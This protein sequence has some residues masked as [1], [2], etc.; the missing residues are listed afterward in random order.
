MS[1]NLH[2]IVVGSS[3]HL[4]GSSS[5]HK[6]LEMVGVNVTS[7][8]A[9]SVERECRSLLSNSQ[10]E[11]VLMV[12]QYATVTAAFTK[13]ALPYVVSRMST[14]H[15]A[16]YIGYDIPLN[17]WSTF[18]MSGVDNRCGLKLTTSC[19]PCVC[20]PSGI[21]LSRAALESALAAF[22]TNNTPPTCIWQQFVYAFK[23]QR[24][25]TA[26]VSPM[27]IRYSSAAML[28]CVSDPDS[29][30]YASMRFAS[31]VL[32]KVSINYVVSW[33]HAH[34]TA[35]MCVWAVSAVCFVGMLVYAINSFALQ[36][37]AACRQCGCR[38]LLLRLLRF[39][40]SMLS[41]K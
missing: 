7:C 25:A 32:D 6:H 40:V 28:E 11:Y 20:C 3:A 12:S 8:A 18:L 16:A 14:D 29:C 9:S 36:T 38:K 15:E 22:S 2:A 23:E 13:E 37:N 30:A 41:D 17:K 39:C 27:M 24:V 4:K 31:K 26:V 1:T 5:L 35:L 34:M 10:L 21:L 33:V 19:T